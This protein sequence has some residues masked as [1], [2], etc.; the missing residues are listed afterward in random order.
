MTAIEKITVTDTETELSL[1]QSPFRDLCFRA[2]I[3]VVIA[4][5]ATI[6]GIKHFDPLAYLDGLGHSVAPM[7]NILGSIAFIL[8]I[9]AL[10]TK[11]LEITL[12]NKKLRAIVR[13]RLAGYSRRLAADLTLWSF[14]ALISMLTSLVI[15]MTQVPLASS[16]YAPAAITIL[17]IVAL[18]FAMSVANIQIRLLRPTPLASIHPGLITLIYVAAFLF[19]TYFGVLNEA[20]V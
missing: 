11:D 17:W 10:M 7:L 15:V 6:K 2:V 5:I 14:G 3:F 20:L 18:I 13:G 16:D 1:K 12:T 4:S 9:P 8:C 19:I